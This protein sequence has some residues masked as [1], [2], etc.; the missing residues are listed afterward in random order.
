MVEPYESFSCHCKRGDVV[1]RKSHKPHS[2]GRLYYTCARSKPSQQDHGCGYF[3]W[4][5]EI[6]FGNASFFWG[7]STPLISSSR[8]SSSSGP[9][10]AALSL[11]NAE[12]SNCK[13]LTMKIKIQEAILATERHPDDH[14]SPHPPPAAAVAHHHHSLLLSLA[15]SIDNSCGRRNAANLYK[16]WDL[17][18]I[19]F[20]ISTDQ[21]DA[22]V[23]SETRGSRGADE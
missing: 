4:K 10:G 19:F 6:T 20:F 11:G 22:R 17:S 1:L 23:E 3:K 2:F 8:A 12:C 14:A 15:L 5:D 18:S 7:L 21:S 9:F 16:R 13:L